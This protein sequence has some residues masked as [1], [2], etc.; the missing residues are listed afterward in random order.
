[1]WLCL[2]ALLLAHVNITLRKKQ[3]S[4]I[5]IKPT[6]YNP[7]RRGLILPRFLID[8]RYSYP[9]ISYLPD[10]ISIRELIYPIVV[11]PPPPHY[12]ALFSPP[13]P[14]LRSFSRRCAQLF[15]SRRGRTGR[16]LER[17]PLARVPESCGAATAEVGFMPRG[18]PGITESRI[19]TLFAECGMVEAG[20]GD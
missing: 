14:Q 8:A 2:F 13:A 5:L 16:G 20:L 17:P 18:A 7:S 6:T 11:S 10:T 9:Q 1:M 12:S 15:F 4:L 19:Y 3:S